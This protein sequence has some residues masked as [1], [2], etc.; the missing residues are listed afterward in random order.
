[1]NSTCAPASLT[2]Q[3]VNVDQNLKEWDV[4][5]ERPLR[6]INKVMIDERHRRRKS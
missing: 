2:A 3:V 5:L 1:M 4:A 6:L